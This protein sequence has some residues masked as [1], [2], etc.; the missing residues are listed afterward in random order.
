MEEL[1]TYLRLAPEFGGT[2]FG[3]FETIE[4]RLGSD[5]DHCHIVLQAE[6]GVQPDHVKLLRQGPKNLI[7]APSA[8]TSM[9]YLWKRGATRPTQLTTPTAVT[10]GDS[11]SLVTPEGPRFIIE[12]DELPEEIKAQ[13]DKSKP[14]R[15]GRSRLSKDSMATEGKRQ[16]FT[17]LLVLGPAQ[18]A[19]RAWIYVKSGA[20]FM[21]RNIIMMGVLASG[22]VFG[23]ASSCKRSKLQ[24]NLKVTNERVEACNEQLGI[25]NNMGDSEDASFSQLAS[26]IVRSNKLGEALES[27]DTLRAE[28]RRRAKG[29]FRDVVK[30]PKKH[31]WMLKGQGKKARDFT[32]WRERIMSLE[33]IDIETRALLVWLGMDVTGRIAKEFRKTLD[34][35]AQEVCTRGPLRMTYRQALSLGISPQADGYVGRNPDRYKENK[36]AREELLEGTILAAGGEGLPEQG[37]FE[38]DVSPVQ[39]GVSACVFIRGEDDRLLLK[40]LIPMMRVGFGDKAKGVPPG[41]DSNGSVARI[42]KFHAADIMQVDFTQPE[43]GIDFS[44]AQVGTELDRWDARGQWVMK[45]TAETIAKAI[46]LPCFAAL[47][48]EAKA[49]EATFG[50]E[51]PQPIPC[52]ILDWKLRNER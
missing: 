26:R 4:V 21:P 2:R 49:A 10:P 12:L 20:I 1:A 51:L 18:M 38:T 27:D 37:T 47:S 9:V 24:T 46:V 7:L 39:Q 45:R 28:V 44:D 19:Q 34:S 23:G 30:S 32:R 15:G 48:G 40:D 36:E 6:L 3:P 52:L 43:P 33:K 41:F 42:A 14:K 16:I 29:L 17:R 31:G 11:F 50:P 35:E 13:R 25:A 5:P 8:R 22:W